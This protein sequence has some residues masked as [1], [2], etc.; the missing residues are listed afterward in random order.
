MVGHWQVTTALETLGLNGRRMDWQPRRDQGRRSNA[1]C[2]ASGVYTLS[3]IEAP[4]GYVSCL[5]DNTAAKEWT[6]YLTLVG[7][8]WDMVMGMGYG[9]WVREWVWVRYSTYL[10]CVLVPQ[11]TPERNVKVSLFLCS[12]LCVCISVSLSLWGTSA[13][14]GVEQLLPRGRSRNWWWTFDAKVLPKLPYST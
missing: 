1:Q 12:L 6:V 7:W 11:I 14:Y 5:N 10:D 2:T 4:G 13:K 8:Y 9:V 3:A